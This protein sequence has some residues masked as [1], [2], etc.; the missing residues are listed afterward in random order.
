MA[1][2]KVPRP[3]TPADAGVHKLLK[4]QDP[5]FRREDVKRGI[6]TSKDVARKSGDFLDRMFP[7]L[8]G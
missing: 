1:S 8:P 2:E 5:G 4:I 3:V 7:R 6:R